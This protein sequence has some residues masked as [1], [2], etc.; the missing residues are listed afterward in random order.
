MQAAI[1]RVIALERTVHHLATIDPIGDVVLS[2]RPR[3]RRDAKLT[4]FVEPAKGGS[5]VQMMTEALSC[6]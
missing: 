4:I 2:F 3:A 1:C 6:D 5:P